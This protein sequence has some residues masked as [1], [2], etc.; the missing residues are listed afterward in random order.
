MDSYKQQHRR[1]YQ[2]PNMGQNSIEQQ[3]L[4][5]INPVINHGM[6]EAQ[7]LGYPNALRESVAISYLMGQGLDFQLALQMVESWWRPQTPTQPGTFY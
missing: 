5:A 6:R 4:S 7:P 2:Q 1:N 3:V